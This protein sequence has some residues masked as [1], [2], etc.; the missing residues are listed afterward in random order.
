MGVECGVSRYVAEMAAGS[1]L[2][3][4]KA[5]RSLM[6]K[7]S[8]MPPFP[9]H[10]GPR[11]VS[12]PLNAPIAPTTR[13][14]REKASLPENG[15]YGSPAR[16]NF[17][18]VAFFDIPLSASK[19]VNVLA[20]VGG[21]ERVRV[22]FAESVKTCHQPSRRA[23]ARAAV[24]RS[25]RNSKPRLRANSPHGGRPQAPRGWSGGPRPVSVYTSSLT[26]AAF[27]ASF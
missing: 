26:A 8:Y 10:R 23:S 5:H 11:V 25:S 1:Q 9:A 14:H 21:D 16:T 3:A 27:N 19:N 24:H 20:I 22:A 13:I 17:N 2:E 18:R 12:G 4:G 15:R 7:I 6:S